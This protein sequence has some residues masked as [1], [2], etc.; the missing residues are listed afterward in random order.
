[1]NY[2]VFKCDNYINSN[3]NRQININVIAMC[4]K[5]SKKNRKNIR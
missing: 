3:S 1:M 4:P 5:K 2:Y